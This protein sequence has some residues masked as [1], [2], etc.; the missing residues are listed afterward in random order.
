MLKIGKSYIMQKDGSARLC[1]DLTIDNRRTTLWF[2]VESWQAG[3]L[4]LGRADAFVMALLPCA[5]RGGHE[6][7]CE[8]PISERLYY[9][10][11]GSL[12]PTLSSAGER[13]QPIKITALLTTEKLHNQGAVG[14]G[15]SGGVDSLYTI[16]RHGEESVFPLTHIAIFNTGNIDSKAA[17]LKLFRQAEIFGE[18]QN[19]KALFIDT[20]FRE[21]LPEYYDSIYTFRNLACVLALQGLYAVYLL[22]SGPNAVKMELNLLRCA[23]YDLLTINCASTESLSFYLSGV[24]TTRVAKLTMLTKWEPSYRWL[25]SCTS[26]VGEN[27]NCSR[28]KKCIRDMTVLYALGKLEQYQGVYDVEDYFRHLPE[29]LGFI[30][31]SRPHSNSGNQAKRLLE[32]RKIPIPPAARIYAKQFHRAIQNLEYSREEGLI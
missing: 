23:R 14:T 4:S 12:I 31:A 7:A 11:I 27:H 22:S 19:L 3:W 21:I 15:F 29:R 13:Y 25:H 30:L 20:N 28:C 1:A 10:L 16:M 9:Q 5:M 17:L 18:A 2:G 26:I 6:I 32:E 8:D 24:E